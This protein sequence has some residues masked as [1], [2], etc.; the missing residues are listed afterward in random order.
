MR[1][2]VVSESSGLKRLMRTCFL[3]YIIKKF[4]ST[5]KV[6]FFLQ[7]KTTV[8]NWSNARPKLDVACVVD[9]HQS[10]V[11]DILS[12]FV[13]VCLSLTFKQR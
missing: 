6:A 13:T 1:S 11:Q 3:Q 7:G 8:T 4:T 9:L 12:V 2:D 5:A 10:Q